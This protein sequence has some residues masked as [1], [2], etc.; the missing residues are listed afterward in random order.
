[1]KLISSAFREGGLIPPNYTCDGIDMSPPLEWIDLPP[2]TI[3]L[4]LMCDDPDAPGGD[5]VHWLVYNIPANVRGLKENIGRD[6]QLANGA[7]QGLTD[8]RR[9]GYN[10]PC[11]PSGIHRYMFRLLALDCLLDLK[12][13][14]SKPRLIA[15]MEGHV[16]AECQLTGRYQRR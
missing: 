6:K 4:T 11:P 2:A 7:L 3:S 9:I 13:G 15:A 12:P 14:T 1:M 10:G 16:I 8:F 5:W